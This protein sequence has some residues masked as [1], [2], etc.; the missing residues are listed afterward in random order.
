MS[1]RDCFATLAACGMLGADGNDGP[2]W[3]AKDAL[4]QVGGGKWLEPNGLARQAYAIA[5]AMLAEREKV[6]E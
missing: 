4:E 6:K 2:R 3:I 5:D 1:V